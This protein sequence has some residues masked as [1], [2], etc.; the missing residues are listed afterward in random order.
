MTVGYSLSGTAEYGTDYTVYGPGVTPS[1][2]FFDVG[3]I[4][5]DIY[6]KAKEDYLDDPNESVIA[7]LAPSTVYRGG[8]LSA[9][10]YV[11]S[12]KWTFSFSSA[13]FAAK[14]AVKTPID[15]TLFRGTT[16][17]TSKTVTFSLT[18]TG[19]ANSYGDS[20]TGAVPGPSKTYVGDFIAG[21]STTSRSYAVEAKINGTKL[22]QTTVTV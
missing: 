13:N 8:G 21:S 15:G 2:V 14:P 18:A 9:T 4:S 22:G 3:E 1:S 7:T 16:A 20:V 11:Q 5:K 19:S 17:D 12:I 10:A 6:V